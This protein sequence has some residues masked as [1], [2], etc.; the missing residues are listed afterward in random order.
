[1]GTHAKQ[2]LV[3]GLFQS[4]T[5]RLGNSLQSRLFPK[6]RGQVRQCQGFFA[7]TDLLVQAISPILQALDEILPRQENFAT[8]VDPLLI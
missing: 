2:F 8:K 4:L 5:K 3:P 6:G 7:L 1:M